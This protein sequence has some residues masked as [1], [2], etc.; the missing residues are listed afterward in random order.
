MLDTYRA[1]ANKLEIKLA[2]TDLLKDVLEPV[3]QALPARRKCRRYRG[4]SK[5]ITQRTLRLKQIMLNLGRNSTKFVHS[6]F[7]RF[8]GSC[9]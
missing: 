8:R 9:C 2:P 6:G 4:L 5:T 1:E 3:Q 7:I